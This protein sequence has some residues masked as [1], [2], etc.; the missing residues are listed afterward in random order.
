MYK[1]YLQNDNHQ[2]S[3]FDNNLCSMCAFSRNC[4]NIWYCSAV[5]A[6]ILSSIVAVWRCTA[7]SN[8]CCNPLKATWIVS[9][10]CDTINTW[11]Y[12]F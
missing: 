7:S 2:N 12:N 8:C 6:R 1:V 10:N 4:S 9:G 3:Y 5:N 11:K